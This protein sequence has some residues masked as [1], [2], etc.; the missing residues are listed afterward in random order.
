MI[1]ADLPTWTYWLLGFVAFAAAAAWWIH[2]GDTL[3]HVLLNPWRRAGRLQSEEQ[4]LDR[5]RR[6]FHEGADPTWQDDLNDSLRSSA[7][8]FGEDDGPDLY[9][10]GV[11]SLPPDRR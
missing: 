6:R 3:K 9:L 11:E 10:P 2:V 5:T 8:F 7:G 1:P 4:I